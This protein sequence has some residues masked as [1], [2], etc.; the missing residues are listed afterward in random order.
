MAYKPFLSHLISDP[1]WLGK[2]SLRLK[3]QEL[4]M[5]E[6]DRFTHPAKDYLALNSS[7]L[8]HFSGAGSGLQLLFL[9]SA[10]TEKTDIT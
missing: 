9:L 1:D 5:E 8:N 7:V 2:N 3:H 10:V 6:T 4:N